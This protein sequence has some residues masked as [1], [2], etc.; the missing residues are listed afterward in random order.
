MTSTSLSKTFGVPVGNKKARPSYK[1]FK[2]SNKSVFI[3]AP[4]YAC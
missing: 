4:L 1:K 2:I 3:P